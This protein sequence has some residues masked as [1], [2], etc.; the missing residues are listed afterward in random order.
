MKRIGTIFLCSFL[1]LSSF[2][3]FSKES[4]YKKKIG[5]KIASLYQ[6]EQGR[7]VFNNLIECKKIKKSKNYLQ[8]SIECMSNSFDKGL[9]NSHKIDLVIFVLG[10]KNFSSLAKCD[11]EVLERHPSVINNEND[12]VLCSD[13]ESG[14]RNRPETSIFFFE[15]FGKDL[16]IIDIKN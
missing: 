6:E 13:Y 11:F 10:A 15:R 4:S 8:E 1:L 7:E 12:F 3:S 9:S 2:T 5:R 16:K 14:S